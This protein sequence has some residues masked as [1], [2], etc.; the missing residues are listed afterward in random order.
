MNI[1]LGSDDLPR[2]Q[3]ANHKLNLV[4][5]Y[6]IS[7]SPEINRILSELNKCNSDIKAKIKFNHNF[8]LNKCKLRLEN[9][10]RWSSSYFVLESVKNAYDK[11]LFTDKCP[12]PV[13]LEKVET[14]ILI[15]KPSYL[16][17]L[18]L[19]RTDSSIAETIPSEFYR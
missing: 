9:K 11:G 19:Q 2:F 16:L 14:Y 1:N 4:I 18:S 5:R 10:T 3:C 15:L 13:G 6:A 12:C 7:K 17:S 8:Y